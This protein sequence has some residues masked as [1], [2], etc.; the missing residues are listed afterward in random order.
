V[1]PAV[2]PDPEQIYDNLAR[3]PMLPYLAA[4]TSA[5]YVGH[6][7]FRINSARNEGGRTFSE[8]QIADGAVNVSLETLMSLASII[9][10]C[11]LPAFH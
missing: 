10:S 6:Y 7:K 1:Y 11:P 5:S 8:Q 3:L 9:Y 4:P 2:V